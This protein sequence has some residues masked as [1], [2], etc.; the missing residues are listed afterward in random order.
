MAGAALAALAPKPRDRVHF[1]VK[2]AAGAMRVAAVL[3]LVGGAAGIYGVFNLAQIQGTE[4]ITLTGMWTVI[5]G[6][7][8]V[9]FAVVYALI[10]WGFADGLVLLADI[11]DAQRRTQREV[12]DLML[13]QRTARGPFHSEA[14]G[15]KES[16]LSR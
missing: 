13:A 1:A 2:F 7:L 10:L 11:D 12:A 4:N 9:A 6:G 8:V 5:V 14:V 3:T 16:Q 15:A